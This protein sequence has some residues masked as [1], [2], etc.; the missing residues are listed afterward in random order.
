[1]SADSPV[2]AEDLLP[3]RSRISWGA[4]IAGSVLALALYFLLTL[5]GGAIGLSISGRA[6]ARAMGT[7]A[8][9][10]AIV[11]TALCLFVGGFVASQL[12]VGENKT[13]AAMYGLLVWAVV[14]AMLLW[15]MAS[16][17]R[18]GFNAMVG[19]ATAG[20]AAV[21][22][23]A[24]NT[25]QEDWEEMARRAGISQQQIDDLRQKAKDAPAQAR[26]AVQD[27]SNQQRAESAAREAGEAVTKASWYTFFGTLIAML[28]A[29]M[30]G[31]RGAGA[32]LRLFP[33]R[34]WHMSRS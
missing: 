27:P 14:F 18:A 17:V 11:V 22:A 29:A 1:M 31:Y 34:A 3:I 26:Q 15:L 33:V 2:H 4:I 20:S 7:A 12:T 19:V 28:A 9:L 25:S 10:W 32:T 24:Q 23:A 13:E 30:G 8:A 5:L 21:G 6:D 16:G